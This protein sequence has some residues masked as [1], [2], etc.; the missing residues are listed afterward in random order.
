[1]H[2]IASPSPVTEVNQQSSKPDDGG[3]D[4]TQDSGNP[5][6]IDESPKNQ[7]DPDMYRDWLI[8]SKGKRSSKVQ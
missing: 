1:M 5:K 8:V 7:G 4:A 2:E 3:K 6:A